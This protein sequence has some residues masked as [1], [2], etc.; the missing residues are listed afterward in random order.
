MKVACGLSHAR[1]PAGRANGEKR[2]EKNI[3]K[4]SG[5]ADSSPYEE[6]S[7]AMG[8]GD[9]RSKG[10]SSPSRSAG[11]FMGVQV[12]GRSMG[13]TGLATK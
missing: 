3:P 10:E 6:K 5:S 2:V 9:S 12:A 13:S 7:L 8:E 1:C 4:S 11:A